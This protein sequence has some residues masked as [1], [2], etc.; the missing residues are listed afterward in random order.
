[1]TSDI[2]GSERFTNADGG[3]MDLIGS[4]KNVSL[5]I[6]DIDYKLD[7]IYVTPESHRFFIIG[8]DVFYEDIIYNIGQNDKEKI[9]EFAYE[10]NGQIVTTTIKTRHN[11][12][13]KPGTL[14]NTRKKLPPDNESLPSPPL[15][16]QG[17]TL[18][19][20]RSASQCLIGNHGKPKIILQRA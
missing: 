16:K 14:E 9:M 11:A 19:V 6:G 2:R 15:R 20:R 5:Q 4:I 10:Q 18:N 12:K 13:P 1:M 8:A 7:V 3:L 17:A